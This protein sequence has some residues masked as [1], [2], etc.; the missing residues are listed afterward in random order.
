M[1][2][3]N[4]LSRYT[5]CMC[6]GSFLSNY[7]Y[8]CSHCCKNIFSHKGCFKLH[9]E[10]KVFSFF[11]TDNPNFLK[12]GNRHFSE[13]LILQMKSCEDLDRFKF[14]AEL[15]WESDQ[16][17]KCIQRDFAT[18]VLYPPS[19]RIG[20]HA[21]SMAMALAEKFGLPCAEAFLPPTIGQETIKSKTRYERKQLDFQR[22]ESFTYQSFRQF[23]VV[24]DLITTGSTLSAC[25]RA[26]GRPQQF[27]AIT[28]ASRKPSK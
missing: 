17:Q 25:Y 8:L 21:K 12:Q 23:I 10:I 19:L 14:F 5:P 2:I 3:L 4:R 11:E 6:C 16:I 15:C 28:L 9:D 22:N 18:V 1:N 13:K 26:L 27:F 20:N 7:F 24:D